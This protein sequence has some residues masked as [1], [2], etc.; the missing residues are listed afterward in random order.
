MEKSKEQYGMFNIDDLSLSFMDHVTVS[1]YFNYFGMKQTGWWAMNEIHLWF[2]SNNYFTVSHYDESNNIYF[3]M[4]GSKSFSLAP[5]K[6]IHEDSEHILYPYLYPGSRNTYYYMGRDTLNDTYKVTIKENEILYVPA[7][8]YHETLN[9]NKAESMAINIW[10]NTDTPKSRINQYLQRLYSEPLPS[11]EYV[12]DDWNEFVYFLNKMS[13]V[14]NDNGKGALLQFFEPLYPVLGHIYD[15]F[16]RIGSD[17]LDINYLN[18]LFDYNNLLKCFRLNP[19]YD[20]NAKTFVYKKLVKLLKKKSIFQCYPPRKEKLGRWD[21]L[22][23]AYSNMFD[24][25]RNIDDVVMEH[26]YV[27][28]IESILLLISHDIGF[29][30]LFISLLNL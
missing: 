13:E 17:K 11:G 6:G 16:R 7:Y 9:D 24:R 23:N 10:F 25:V 28:Y 30:M 22:I 12:F 21:Q 15:D 26:T 29:N 14:M 1:P 19:Y 4:R 3:M 8:W 2:G 5:L 20:K 18:M 27:K